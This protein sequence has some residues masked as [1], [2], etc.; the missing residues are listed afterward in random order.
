M[1]YFTDTL[2]EYLMQHLPSLLLHFMICHSNKCHNTCLQMTTTLEPYASLVLRILML[3]SIMRSI[4]YLLFQCLAQ[5]HFLS[6][7]CVQG[8][9]VVYFADTLDEYL[10]QH[11]PSN[12]DHT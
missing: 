10:M 6:W 4:F 9:E 8:Y 7:F 1:V 12:D 2:D 11:L 5:V 3:P